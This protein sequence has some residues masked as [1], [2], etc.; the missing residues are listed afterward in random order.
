MLKLNRRGLIQARLGIQHVQAARPA[1]TPFFRVSVCAARTLNATGQS[2]VTLS[3]RQEQLRA[4]YGSR[5]EEQ[6]LAP[7]QNDALLAGRWRR[8]GDRSSD[9]VCRRVTPRLQPARGPQWARGGDL[10]LAGAHARQ[11][12]TE[13]DGVTDDIVWQLACHGVVLAQRQKIGTDAHHECFEKC[14]KVYLPRLDRPSWHSG[15]TKQRLL[16]LP[17]PPAPALALLDLIA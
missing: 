17:G 13:S 10:E 1:Q 3:L 4:V 12:K 16:C 7:A 15:D 8:R 9:H 6:G 14:F 5:Q 2:R 11:Y